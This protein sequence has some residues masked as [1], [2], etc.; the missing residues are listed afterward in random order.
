MTAARVATLSLVLALGA[1]CASAPPPHGAAASRHGLSVRTSTTLSL[2]MYPAAWGLPSRLIDTRQRKAVSLEE[3]MQVMLQS[4]VIYVGESHD[5]P[6]HHAVQGALFF[7]LWKA[8]RRLAVGMEM[9]QRPFQPA[10]DAWARG[11]IDVATMLERTEYED[12]WGHDFTLYRPL[13][14]VAVAHGVRLIALNATREIT[15]K[16]AREGEDALTPQERAQVPELDRSSVSHRAMIRE[17][18]DQ[19]GLPAE[20]FEAFYT[21]QLVWDETMAQVI[22]ETFTST[23][24]P[25]RMLV[26]AGM[27]HVRAGLGIP[28]RAARRGAKPHTIVVPVL[29]TE[30]GPSLVSLLEDPDGDFL[31]LM[32]MD[33]AQLPAVGASI[34]DPAGTPSVVTDAGAASTDHAPRA[35]AAAPLLPWSVRR[36]SAARP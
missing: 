5:N 12:R 4:R 28:K 14:E 1:A 34:E 36:A 22:A 16:I 8:D 30:D 32:S 6:H 13:A 11:E 18:F 20:R 19:H 35:R 3:A 29:L 31:W 23:N 2:G 9:F 25:T 7:A 24:A 26:M 10:L 17:A 33:P 15:R 27:G 21:A